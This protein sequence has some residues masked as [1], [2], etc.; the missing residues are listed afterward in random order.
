[1]A[2][3]NADADRNVIPRLRTFEATRA[4][5][6]LDSLVGPRGHDKRAEGLLVAKTA[7][8]REHRTIGHASDLVGTAL[9]L[10]RM[11]RDVVEAAKLLVGAKGNVSPWARE[12][13][14]IA[15]GA[16][17]IEGDISPTQKAEQRIEDASLYAQVRTFRTL[18]SQEPRDPVT[19]VDLAFAYACVGH[20]ERAAR[21]MTVA[22]QLSRDNRF[23]LRS[24][25]R[26]W[27]YLDDP[28]RAYQ[29][30]ARSARTMY[31]P[32]LLAA[33][34]ALGSIVGKGRG[35]VKQARRMIGGR[36]FGARQISELAAA[37]ASLELSSGSIRK[38]KRLFA[39]S[40]EDPTEN[41]VAQVSWAARRYREIRIDREYSRQLIAFEAAAWTSYQNKEWHD[42]VKNSKRWFGDQPFSRRPAGLGSFVATTALEDYSAGK[43]F[44]A[45]GLRANPGDFTLLNNLAFA[46]LQLGNIPEGAEALRKVDRGGLSEGQSI[47]LKATQGLMSFRSGNLE[48]GRELYEAALDSA[49]RLGDSNGPRIHALAS[50]FYALEELAVGGPNVDGVCGDALRSAAKV[51]DPIFEPLERRL[52]KKWGTRSG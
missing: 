24:A 49:R 48:Q 25:G 50:M 51:L 5:G 44:A 14:N 9:T 10:G 11:D 42:V 29:V 41:S 17:G 7:E 47:V 19:W 27:I 3:F 15:V 16:A 8:W 4:L 21:A 34:I 45:K 20:R 23:I 26:L 30:V 37:L 6:E 12:L 18:L 28:E 43:W 52:R 40:L 13:G 1:M 32:W 2:G 46:C 35:H 38:A 39:R 36:R 22:M 31:D 33:D